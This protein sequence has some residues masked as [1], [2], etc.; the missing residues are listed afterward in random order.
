MSTQNAA[1]AATAH[2]HADTVPPLPHT[3][4]QPD[5]SAT[6]DSKLDTW[7]AWVTQAAAAGADFAELF[8]LEVR[9][10]VGDARR[11]L[12]LMLMAVPLLLLAWLG[13]S[14][15]IAWLV[16]EYRSSVA[17]GIG[18][19]LGIQLVSLGALACLWQRYK[20]SLK[21]PLTRQYL[22]AFMGGFSDEARSPAAPH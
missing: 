18:T 15:L 14:T 19:F 12:V 6:H 10:A 13:F 9:L 4:R 7:S 16:G 8:S 5:D 22:Q 21:L 17:W 2:P 20:Q 11:L 3:D 1:H